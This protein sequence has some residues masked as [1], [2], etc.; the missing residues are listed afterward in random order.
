MLDH[1]VYVQGDAI[2]FAAGAAADPASALPTAPGCAGLNCPTVVA[3][4]TMTV[5]L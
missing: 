3:V 5:E 1:P 4:M 2:A